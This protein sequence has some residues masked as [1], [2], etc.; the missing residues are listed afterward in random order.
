MVR[1][2]NRARLVGYTRASRWERGAPSRRLA[3]QRRELEARAQA[4]GWALIRVEEDALAGRTLRRPGLQAALE[5]CRRGDADGIAV[6]RLDRLT[7]SLDDLASL[8]G[9][10][11]GRGFTIVALDVGL[12]LHAPDAELL[13]RVFDLARQWGRRELVRQRAH[14]VLDR[15]REGR[16]ARGRP[17]STPPD[18]AARIRD[19]RRRGATLQAICDILNDEGVPTPRGGAH[20]RPTS[21]RAVLRPMNEGEDA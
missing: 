21:L 4:D 13:G 19:L 1:T 3:A 20:W 16:R 11:R 17:P 10:A 18:V 2:V 14:D 6:T 5:A 12:D 15:T 7:R 8:V 9:E